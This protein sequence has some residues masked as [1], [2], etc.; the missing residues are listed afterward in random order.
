MSK[1][2][3]GSIIGITKERQSGVAAPHS[4]KL[5]KQNLPVH[6]FFFL[7]L[8]QQLWH[9][10]LIPKELIVVEVRKGT[11]T[12]FSEAKSFQNCTVHNV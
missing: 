9:D 2:E 3:A 4:Q 7:K 6:L 10:K 11:K 8:W 12:F 1:L 5:E